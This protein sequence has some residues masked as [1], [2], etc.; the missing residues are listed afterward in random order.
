[1]AYPRT[2]ERDDFAHVDDSYAG[3]CVEFEEKESEARPW[4]WVETLEMWW[5]EALVV[6]KEKTV[7]EWNLSTKPSGLTSIE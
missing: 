7:C 1:V 3:R 6:V 4:F 5:I 2:V